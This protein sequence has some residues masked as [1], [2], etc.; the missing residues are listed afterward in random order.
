M[1]KSIS[2]N[3]RLFMSGNFLFALS[4]G[5]WMN[6]R[7]IHLLDLDATPAQIGTVFA[8]VSL[9]GGLLPLP[10]GILSDR[11]GPKRVVLA[12]WLIA[13]AGTL[14]AALAHT[15]PLAAVGYIIFMLCIAANPATISY[16]LL[17][18][19]DQD[20]EGSAERVMATVFASWPAAM[21]FAPAL[22]GWIADR[23]SIQADLWM[24]TIGLLM[25]VGSFSLATDTQR[26][27]VPGCSGPR[28]LLRNRQFIA[29]AAYFSFAVMALYLGFILAPTYLED[30]QGFS[31]GFIGVMFSL[32][33]V[34]TLLFRNVVIKCKPRI[35]FAVLVGAACLGTLALWQVKGQIWTGAA[36]VLLGA[37][38]TTWVVMQASIG[39]SVPEQVRGLALGLTE[40]LYYGGVAVVS[41]LAGQLYGWTTTHKLP[42][43]YGSVA[44]LI[45]LVVWTVV[46]L[47]RQTLGA[48]RKTKGAVQETNV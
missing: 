45:V 15:W 42:F 44:M 6:L 41:W 34:G 43:I 22:G 36:F 24:G 26:T 30:A 39:R 29:L 37:I 19:T 5:L 38:S 2:R 14:I 48:G 21:I 12:A 33:S 4:Y 28:V 31:T 35:S 1:F 10:A 20:R 40:S 16:V 25:A 8:L 17:N 3:N 23:W 18:T 27:S 13:S 32:S 7:Q 46:P 11:I 9:A 47:D